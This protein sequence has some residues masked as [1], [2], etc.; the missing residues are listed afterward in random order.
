[1]ESPLILISFISLPEIWFIRYHWWY[2]WISNKYSSEQSFVPWSKF[3]T[4]QS[5]KNRTSTI[6]LR[7]IKNQLPKSLIIEAPRWCQKVKT[8]IFS[9]HW[10]RDFWVYSLVRPCEFATELISN[11]KFKIPN[12]MLTRFVPEAVL[13][14]LTPEVSG[15]ARWSSGWWKKFHTSAM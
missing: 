6:H 9:S 3:R 1:M 10:N 4:H 15:R 2:L 8:I 5:W 14:R 13:I 11:S 7:Y 12:R